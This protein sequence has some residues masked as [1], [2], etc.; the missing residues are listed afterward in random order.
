MWNFS[1]FNYSSNNSLECQENTAKPICRKVYK[2]WQNGLKEK[3]RDSTYAVL[4][5]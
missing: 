2:L 5:I 4:L 1:F 3:Q